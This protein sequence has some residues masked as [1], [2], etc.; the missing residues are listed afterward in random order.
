MKKRSA[1]GRREQFLKERSSQKPKAPAAP[2]RFIKVRNVALTVEQINELSQSCQRKAAE[3]EHLPTMLADQ[4]VAARR[5]AP[6][7]LISRGKNSFDCQG[8]VPRPEEEKGRV[9]NQNPTTY[10]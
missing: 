6:R 2:I 5:E 1:S 4:Q 3:A 10:A 9:R 8:I 7:P